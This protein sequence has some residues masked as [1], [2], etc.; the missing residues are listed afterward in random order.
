MSNVEILNTIDWNDKK[1]Y[2]IFLNLLKSLSKTESVENH[3][4]HVKILNTQLPVYA[5]SMA[6][7]RLVAKN[8]FNSVKNVNVD[9]ILG[10]HKGSERHSFLDEY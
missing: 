6:N 1:S 9:D 7:I 5:L 8:I 10:W 4:R 2:S 3:A